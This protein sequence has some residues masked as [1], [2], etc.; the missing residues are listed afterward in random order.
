MAACSLPGCHPWA[1]HEQSARA[2]VQALAHTQSPGRPSL[3]ASRTDMKDE[4]E[5]DDGMRPCTPPTL[6]RR[7]TRGVLMSSLAHA[8]AETQRGQGQP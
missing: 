4:H 8:D 2:S 5:H 3:D 7:Y 1:F 6:T